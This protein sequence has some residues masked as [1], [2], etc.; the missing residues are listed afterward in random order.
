MRLPLFRYALMLAFCLSLSMA[1][2]LSLAAERQQITDWLRLEMDEGQGWKTK[3]QSDPRYVDIYKESTSG[4]AKKIM[5]IYRKSSSAYDT[6]VSKILLVM[7]DKKAEVSFTAVFVGHDDL[8]T[9]SVVQSAEGDGYDLIYAVGSSAVRRV[10]KHYKGGSLPVVTVCAKDPVLMGQIDDYVSGSHNNFAFTSLNASTDALVKYLLTLKPDLKNIAVLYAKQ[11]ESARQTQYEPMLAL[12]DRM[13]VNVLGVGVEDRAK[14]VLELGDLIPDALM[15][16]RKTDPD[17]ENS[18]FWIT[19]S[20]SVFQEINTIN[21]LTGNV[22][23]LSVVTNVVGEGP[24]TAVMSIGISF[25]SNAH[26]AAIYGLNILNGADPGSM[27]VGQVSPPD[28][29]ISFL[30]A[31]QIGMSIPFEFFEIASSIYNNH[32]GIA[33]KAGKKTTN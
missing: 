21:S 3:V 9:K 15:Q 19:G 6:A 18:I 28:I 5:L 8:F 29:S 10:F 2:N 32:G 27:P 4:Q 22:P 24:D 30:K 12:S 23:V 13:N 25:E 14:T 7:G 1:A 17:L 11:N 16:M 26:L 33:R 31:Q 20:T